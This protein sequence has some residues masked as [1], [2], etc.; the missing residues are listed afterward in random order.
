MAFKVMYYFSLQ[1][2]SSLLN[3]VLLLFLLNALLWVNYI[4]LNFTEVPIKLF[5][6]ELNFKHKGH[7]SLG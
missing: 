2:N 6:I 4:V 1:S 3:L 7:F 5:K